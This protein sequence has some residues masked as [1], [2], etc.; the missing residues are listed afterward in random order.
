MLGF[1]SGADCQ[2]GKVYAWK[3]NVD[4]R[5]YLY[6]RLSASMSYISYDMMPKHEVACM[7][8]S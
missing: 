6:E 7:L 1:A 8:D 2:I 4:T 3:K 5:A